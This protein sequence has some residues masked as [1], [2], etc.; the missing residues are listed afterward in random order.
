MAGGEPEVKIHCPYIG[1]ADEGIFVM[2]RA[3][4]E[5]EIIRNRPSAPAPAAAE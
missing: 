4:L 1:S 5:E 3:Q 2:M